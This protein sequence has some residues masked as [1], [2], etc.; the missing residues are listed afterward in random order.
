MNGTDLR[1]VMELLGHKNLT[2]A[3][4]YSRLA[5]SHKI[6]AVKALDKKLNQYQLHNWPKKGG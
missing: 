3:L 2:M 4:R 1:T 6:D 5:P